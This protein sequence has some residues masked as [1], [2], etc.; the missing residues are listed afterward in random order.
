MH[1]YTQDVFITEIMSSNSATIA[2]EYGGYEDWIELYNASVDSINIQGFYLSDNAAVPLKWQFPEFW[3]PPNEYRIVFASGRDVIGAEYLHTNFKISKEGEPLLFSSSSGT[4]ITYVPP[5]YIPTDVSFGR[6]LDTPEEWV[7]FSSPTPGSEN[8]GSIYSK[9]LAPVTFS[10]SGGFYD[11]PFYLELS[12]S[13][14]DVTILYTLDGSEPSFES[15]GGRTY[16]YKNTYSF[17]PEDTQGELLIDTLYSYIYENPIFLYNRSFDA[18]KLTQK[19]STVHSVSYSPLSPVFKANVV[20]AIAVKDQ[21]LWSEIASHTFF[22]SPQAQK[23]YTIP[24]LSLSVSEDYLFDYYNGIYTAGIDADIWR[25]QNPDKTFEWVFPGNYHRRGGDFEYPIHFEMFVPGKEFSVLN[26]QIGLRIHG[27]ATRAYPMKSL[28]LYARSQY[29]TASIDYPL[30]TNNTV[31]SFK[32]LILRNSGNDFTTNMWEPRFSSKTMFRDGMIQTL[33]KSVF[34]GT[35]DYQPSIVFINGEF[36]GIHNMRE[37]YDRYYL[38]SHF[39]VDP[40]NVDIVDFLF[41]PSE[42]SA[43][44]FIYT[45]TY[46]ETHPLH[47]QSHYDKVKELIDI[48]NF[49]DYYCIQIFSRNTDWPGNNNTAWRLQTDSYIPDAPFGHDGR[50]RWLLYDTDFGFGLWEHDKAYLHNTLK[51]ALAENGPSWPNPP[52]ATLLLRSLLENDEFRQKFINRFDYHITQTFY[53]PRVIGIIDSLASLI[54]PYIPEHSHRWCRGEL[55]LS[56]WKANVQIMRDFAQKRP[57]VMRNILIEYFDIDDPHFADGVCEQLKEHEFVLFPMPVK[58][59][60][61]IQYN[62]NSDSD[63]ILKVEIFDILGRKKQEVTEPN[64]RRMGHFL[65]ELD[66][67]A[68]GVYVLVIHTKSYKYYKQFIVAD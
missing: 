52:S 56:Q 50:W 41:T 37:R 43:D 23:R 2:D 57:C 46:I 7:Y 21:E 33:V 13:E 28:R 29:G 65:I 63:A 16:V 8:S 62:L 58:N 66:N 47:I 18:D 31:T 44:H 68:S 49:I 45:Y 36:W 6:L 59:N 61:T 22:I 26:Q 12:H 48:D 4:V 34:P 17:K 67:F 42:G 40:E 11:S 14:A 25:E 5:H 53:P 35:Q 64:N 54:E 30:F 27:G 60:V 32:R 38:E 24:V 20:R 19:S 15:I 3:I 39:G 1:G 51:F 9:I 10:Q 55:T